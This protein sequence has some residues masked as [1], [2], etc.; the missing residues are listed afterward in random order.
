MI[1]NNA[2]EENITFI[3][4]VDCMKPTHLAILIALWQ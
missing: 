2:G 4:D 1:A 3:I